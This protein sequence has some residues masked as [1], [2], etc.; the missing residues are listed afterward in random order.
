[1]ISLLCPTRGRPDN[2]RR[3]ADSARSTS[4]TPVEIVWYVDS[5]DIASQQVFVDLGDAACVEKHGSRPLSDMWNC[6]ARVSSGDILGMMGDDVV[7]RTPDWDQVV[8]EVFD[9]FSDRIAFV[10]GRDGLQDSVL[11]THGFVS[12]EWV[13]ATGRM[14]GGFFEH[15]YADTWLNDVAERVGRRVFVPDVLIEHMHPDAG[16]APLDDTYE[17]RRGIGQATL[18]EQ[19]APE[20]ARDAEK[21]RRAMEEVHCE[22]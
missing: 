1:M 4:S 15:D 19:L 7:F 16:K 5:D 14:T 20:R 17:C 6:C 10:Y 13:Q 2:M 8:A 11:G 21:L 22:S 12:R 3:F 9:R 18:Y